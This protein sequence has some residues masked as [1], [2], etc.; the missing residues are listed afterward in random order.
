MIGQPYRVFG[1]VS[2]NGKPQQFNGESPYSPRAVLFPTDAKLLNRAASGRCG[3]PR[4]VRWSCANPTGGM[5]HRRMAKTAN[6]IR[7]AARYQPHRRPVQQLGADFKTAW[8]RGRSK[9]WLGCAYG[10]TDDYERVRRRP[11]HR[12]DHGASGTRTRLVPS[13]QPWRPLFILWSFDR[14]LRMLPLPR[15][16]R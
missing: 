6:K 5:R 9:T 12:P 16:P 7:A 4:S 15:M 1:G 13:S 11:A 3:W 2:E 8:E 14:I 10:R